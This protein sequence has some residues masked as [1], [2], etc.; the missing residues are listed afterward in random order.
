[1]GPRKERDE[2]L[3][4]FFIPVEY[5][6]QMG[7]PRFERP[8]AEM[9]RDDLKSGR[10]ANSYDSDCSATWSGCQS[11]DCISD[12]RADT[13]DNRHELLVGSANAVPGSRIFTAG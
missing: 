2:G 5:I 10:A 3:I 11:D 13:S 1:M 7:D 6:A 8:V 12:V 9:P 4:Q